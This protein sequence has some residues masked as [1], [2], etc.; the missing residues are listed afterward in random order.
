VLTRFD[1]VRIERIAAHLPSR[2]I[3]TAELFEDAA[4]LV[5]LTGIEHRH[6]AGEDEATSDLAIAAA[7]RVVDGPVS[8]VV[9]ATAS[10][11][12]PS[13][14]TAPL[15][16]HAL[17]LL[18]CPAVDLAAAC[19]GFV[20]ALDYAARA[21]LTGDERVL[22]TA[23]EVKSRSLEDAPPGVRCLFGDG[24]CAA[25]V[26]RGRGRLALDA[27]LL[28]ADGSGHSLVRVPAG[29]S[30]RP[31]SAATVR[32]KLHSVVIEDGAHV[33][34]AAVDGFVEVAGKLLEGVGLSAKDVAW[35]VPHQPNVRI[36]ERVAKLLEIPDGR[37]ISI[38]KDIANVGGA[39][40]GIALA[41]LLET[42]ELSVGERVLVLTAG[43]GF[44]AGAALFTVKE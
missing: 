30:R 39:S 15:I 20:Y 8:R 1:D 3:S 5:R 17:G 32:E 36:L 44:T 23:A 37:M 14:G 11:D 16:Q 38:A 12:H 26:V 24:A 2:K 22:V 31:T 25:T 43:A 27:T 4:E 19:A 40:A 18:P 10:P 29:G 6:V 35:F 33:F 28:V 41:H 21:V 42:R 9:L 13:P 7:R 34:F